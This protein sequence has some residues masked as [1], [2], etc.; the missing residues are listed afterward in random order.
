MP[1]GVTI[2]IPNVNSEIKTDYK[3]FRQTK[4]YNIKNY[5]KKNT[6]AFKNTTTIGAYFFLS[7]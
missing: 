6:N 3:N 5:K 1:N 7:L 4:V 2:V